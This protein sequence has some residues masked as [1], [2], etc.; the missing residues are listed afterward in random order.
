MSLHGARGYMRNPTCHTQD[1]A[2][3]FAQALALQQVTCLDEDAA[4]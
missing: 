2:C 4:Q 3:L 1:L